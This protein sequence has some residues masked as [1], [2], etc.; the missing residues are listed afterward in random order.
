MSKILN[1][2]SNQK[3]SLSTNFIKL[4]LLKTNIKNNN[5]NDLLESLNSLNLGKKSLMDLKLNELID[6]VNIFLDILNSS[7]LS[8]F[9]DITLQKLKILLEGAD[10]KL[11][12]K[13]NSKTEPNE[14]FK[15]YEESQFQTIFK[16]EYFS[17]FPVAKKFSS[18]SQQILKVNFNLK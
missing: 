7:K 14:W 6:F 17:K 10:L 4:E 15:Q 18:L 8:Q 13:I 1:K 2:L 3:L 5:S 11:I 12:F 9:H 16:H